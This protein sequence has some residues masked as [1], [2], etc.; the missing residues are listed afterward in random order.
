MSATLYELVK[1][2]ETFRSRQYKSGKTLEV[3]V[4]YVPS[5]KQLYIQ[6]YVQSGT[7]KGQKY[8]VQYVFNNVT[9]SEKRTRIHTLKYIDTDGKKYWIERADSRKMNI[10]TRCTCFTGDTLIPLADGYSVPIKDLVGREEFH[11]YS[12]DNLEKRVKIGKGYNCESKGIE[13]VY[14]V[15]F[16]N[17][18]SIKCTGDHKFLMKS[19]EYKEL[20]DII[21]G[22][23]LMP[24][25]RAVSTSAF[26]GGYEKVLNPLTG[27]SN[28]THHLSAEYNLKYSTDTC[29]MEYDENTHK[30]RRVKF[31]EDR[32]SYVRHHIDVNKLNNSPRNIVFM[33]PREHLNL[34][35][36]DPYKREETSERMKLSNPMKNRRVVRKMVNTSRERGL[37]ENCGDRFLDENGNHCVYKMI[38]EGR[39]W[40]DNPEMI[41]RHK[42]RLRISAED[43]TNPYVGHKFIR[44]LETEEGKKELSERNEKLYS[45]GKHSLQRVNPQNWIDSFYKDKQ[46]LENT[47]NWFNSLPFGVSILKYS[48]FMNENRNKDKGTT[49]NPFATCRELSKRLKLN[50]S[51][52]KYKDEET[53]KWNYKIDKSSDIVINHK[54]VSIEEIGEEEVFCFTVED[55]HNFAIDLDNGILQSSGVFVHNCDDSRFVGHWYIADKKALLGP[56]IPYHRVP[57]STRPSKN[58]DHIPVLCKHQLEILRRLMSGRVRLLKRD[59]YISN[60]IN[61]LKRK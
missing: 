13:K 3:K 7:N 6:G 43:G 33:D 32:T 58:P 53:G 40:T 14:K 42:E 37:Y 44:H 38:E 5:N 21:P 28:F 1:Y 18:N 30:T 61:R 2:T 16:D 15:T 50:N 55:Y 35:C 47:L 51:F 45:E 60:Y 24:L 17:G 23:S 26:L 56:R 46:R 49:N 34:H 9:W 48:D 29:W 31:K 39:H 59:P 10:L 57:G 52:E 27:G 20:L 4:K 12:F 19:G 41:E 22:E 8:K 11:V 25:Y 36:K 54:I